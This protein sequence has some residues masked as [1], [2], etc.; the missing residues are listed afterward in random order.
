MTGLLD[1]IIKEI[2]I[3]RSFRRGQSKTKENGLSRVKKISGGGR[4][5]E[6]NVRLELRLF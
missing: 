4:L 2:I 6:P 1:S 5:N 3:A